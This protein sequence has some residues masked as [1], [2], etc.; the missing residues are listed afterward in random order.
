MF[1]KS[2]Q[3]IQDIASDKKIACNK[4]LRIHNYVYDL[5]IEIFNLD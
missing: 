1:N 3:Y 5:L 4:A 2:L